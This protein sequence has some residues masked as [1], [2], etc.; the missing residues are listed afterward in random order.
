M[1]FFCFV[2]CIRYIYNNPVKAGICAK[3]EEYPY[4]NY[5]KIKSNE[6]N[7]NYIFID[8]DEDEDEAEK[9]NEIINVFLQENNTSIE[10]IKKDNIKLRN[11]VKI[12]KNE[13]KISLRKIAMEL[14]L[15]R[16][17]IRR[18]YSSK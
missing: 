13:Y 7:E 2:I 9:C 14:Q 18:I 15:S 17:R 10:R 16:E 12:L 8:V 6:K 3:P 5:K 1:Y 4:S 11:L